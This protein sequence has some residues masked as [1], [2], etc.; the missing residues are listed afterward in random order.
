MNNTKVVSTTLSLA[1]LGIL[2]S[3]M[4]ANAATFTPLTDLTDGGFNQLLGEGKFTEDFI[5]ESRIGISGS[6]DFEIDIQEV[7]PPGPGGIPQPTAEFE[8]GNNQPVDFRLEYDGSKVIY[9]VGGIEL[10]K[11]DVQDLANIN[12]IF[13]RTRSNGDGSIAEISNLVV[14]DMAYNGIVRSDDSDIIDYLKITDIGNN[15]VVTGT[16]NFAWV[17]GS[18]PTRSELAY[19]FKV[20]T[21]GM[22]PSHSVPE[23]ASVSLISLTLLGGAFASTRRRRK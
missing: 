16:S 4:A 10:M 18:R 20:G 9:T 3:A 11:E 13:L 22:P 17:D 7:E 14:D 1:T 15:F 8:W 12:S 19:Q 2:N 5:A 6:G 23:P 21:M